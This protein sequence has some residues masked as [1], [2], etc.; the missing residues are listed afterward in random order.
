MVLFEIVL[1][2]HFDVTSGQLREASY[3]LSH[4][5]S[6]KII[7]RSYIVKLTSATVPDSRI[8]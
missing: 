2:T 6:L 1:T 5:H 4:V 8:I 3:P 7:L